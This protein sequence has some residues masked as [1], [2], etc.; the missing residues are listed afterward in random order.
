MSLRRLRFFLALFAALALPLEAAAGVVMPMGGAS[1]AAAAAE[2][3][4]AMADDCP[5][6]Q[7]QAPTPSPSPSQD[8]SHCGICHLAAAGFIAGAA[9]APAV[10]PA[11]E[12][13]AAAVQA[14]PASH[15]PEPPQQPPKRSA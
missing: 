14:A 1:G 12:T 9:A 6:R 8:C 2:D 11:G 3:T 4:A 7:Q 15:I 10:L 5:M 13:Y